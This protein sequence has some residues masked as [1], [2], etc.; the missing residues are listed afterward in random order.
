MEVL[1]GGRRGRRAAKTV[2][3]LLDGLAGIILPVPCESCGRG[4]GA[5]EVLVCQ[6]C[7]LEL[8]GAGACVFSGWRGTPGR[9]LMDYGGRAAALVAHV[10]QRQGLRLLKRLAAAWP[11]P[12]LPGKLLVPVPLY[13]PRRRE[14]GYN[15]AEWLARCWSRAWGLPW[16]PLLE[17]IRGGQPQKELGRTERLRALEKAF[18]V[19]R[20]RLARLE[21]GPSRGPVLLVD[22]VVTTGATMEQ[23]AAAL[24][25]AGLRVSGILALART[26]QRH[27]PP[28]PPEGE[29]GSVGD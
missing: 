11:R 7:L 14:R 21:D 23:C 13:P 12:P 19:D 15:Q 5:R 2:A 29:A 28:P 8:L 6:P 16:D 27:P 1:P 18:A 10:K 4:L 25:G 20:R 9:A 22:D 3:A 26:A 17:R 24:S